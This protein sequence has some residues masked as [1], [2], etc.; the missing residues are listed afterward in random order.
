MR[1]SRCADMP[2][3]SGV[4]EGRPCAPDP[5]AVRKAMLNTRPNAMRFALIA[6]SLKIELQQSKGKA[7]QYGCQCDRRRRCRLQCALNR[8]ECSYCV[9][10]GWIATGQ[11]SV[12]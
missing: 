1:A 7:A 12:L 8:R 6:D 3:D 9:V 5:A 4:A 2:T 11:R 10:L